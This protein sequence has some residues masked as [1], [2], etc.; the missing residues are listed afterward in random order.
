MK[1][2]V[3][4]PK[5]RFVRALAARL[6][7]TAACLGAVILICSS[8]SAE[9][10]FVTAY[11]NTP[12]SPNVSADSESGDI[13]TDAS[14]G[15]VAKFTWDGKQS[16]F[17]RGLTAPADLV[18]DNAGNLFLTDC[19]DCLTPH[20]SLVIYKVT[21]N[22]VWTTFAL[23]TPYHTAYLA[24]D[25]AGNLFVADYDHGVINRY[26]S[27]GSR[28]TFASGLYHPVG[29]VCDSAGNLYVA[30]NSIGNLHQG[31]IY[32]YTPDGSRVALAV[33]SLSDRPSDLAFD[34]MGNLLMA[35]LG[36][37]IYKYELYS[38]LRRQGRIV[39]G[40]VPNSA[41]SLA[42]DSANNLF[43][44]DAGDVNGSGNAIYKFTTQAVRTPFAP[45]VLGESFSC[46]AVQPMACCEG[47]YS[48][49]RAT[50]TPRPRPTPTPRPG[51]AT[52]TSPPRPT[53]AP[54]PEAVAN[55]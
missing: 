49:S 27:S 30:D 7:C 9:N 16:I 26:K 15:A 10:L 28:S 13:L 1:T 18:F 24:T 48:I 22:G 33:L 23:E 6:I 12:N 21:P 38:P 4:E 46:L 37:K 36:G 44:V 55:H 19:S 42:R 50:P 17:A 32:R 3:T 5:S 8:A 53:P 11:I 45:S 14:F 41:R 35:D 25:N 43:V 47:N 39:F 40:S 51:A 52:T 34:T 54:R 31:S 29:M 20:A 2:K